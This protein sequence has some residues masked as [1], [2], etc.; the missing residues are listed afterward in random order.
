[1]SY[2]T[3]FWLLFKRV[4]I[5]MRVL[6]F[7]EEFVSLGFLNENYKPS[8]GG[9]LLRRFINLITPNWLLIVGSINIV[10]LHNV[11]TTEGIV[12]NNMTPKLLILGNEF[13]CCDL[14]FLWVVFLIWVDKSEWSEM[15]IIKWPHNN[16]Q[17]RGFCLLY[18][19]TLNQNESTTNSFES[20]LVVTFFWYF[21]RHILLIQ[22]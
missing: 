8:E 4:K 21:N 15:T 2:K 14:L 1:M 16:Q 7:V 13:N 3:E 11:L 9:E 6:K 19:S 12:Y 17:Q 18:K 20:A 5:Q 22:L 10:Q